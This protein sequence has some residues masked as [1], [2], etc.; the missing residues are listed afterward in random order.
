MGAFA[1]HGVADAHARDLL[2]T[3]SQYEL[4]HALAALT[5]AAL[6]QRGVRRGAPAA[7]A[8]LAGTVLFSGSLYGLALGAPAWVGAITPI[9]G[10]LF[11]A[12]WAI[13]AMEGNA[14]TRA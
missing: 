14:L 1:A 2:R 5:C 3:G 4:I 11:V 13:L 6:R 8:F 12:G 7:L 9:G 10:L